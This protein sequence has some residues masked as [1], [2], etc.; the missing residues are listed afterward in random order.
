MELS[1]GTSGFELRGADGRVALG[2]ALPAVVATVD[3][4]RREWAPSV[5]EERD[6]T[7]VARGGPGGLGIELR[8]RA[9]GEAPAVEA[10]VVHPG[11]RPLHVD[12]LDLFAADGLVVGEDP[13]RWR[14]Y[15]NGYQSWAGTRTIGTEESDRDVP[16]QLVRLSTTD[17]RHRSPS[18]R[19][20]VR[21]DAVGA[22]CEPVT[23]DALAV[24]LT[25]ESDAFGFV[26]LGSA[27]ANHLSVWVDLDGVPLEPGAATPWFGA[28]LAAATGRDAG[29]TALRSVLAAVG[30]DHGALGRDRPH[31]AG[32]CSWYYY[33][34][35]V[36]EADVVE[37]LEVLAAD[38]R[39]GPVFGCE[40]VMV[41]DG[42]QRAIGDWL[43]TD[44]TK[45]PS[46]MAAVAQRITG[47]GFDAGLWW[48]PFLVDPD[49]EVAR[50]HPDWLVRNA[51]GRPIVGILNPV[52]SA[53]RPMQVLDT[54]H[55]EVL[56]HLE[57]VARVVGADWGYRI[58][59]LD[60]LYAAALP[61]RRHDPA[62]TRAASLRRG[63]EAV[64]RGA[65]GDGFL[66]GCGC[67]LGPAVG[68]VDA[69]RI[70]ADVTPYWSNAID[71]VGGGGWHALATRNAVQDTCARSPFDG[72]WWL[73]DPDCL[74]V[75]D[76]DTRLTEEEVRTLATVIGMTDG[77]V[78]LSDR[79]ARLPES[80]RRMI[81]TVRDLAGGR[82]EVADL[83]ERPRPEVLVSRRAGRTDV[84][85]VN[86]SDRPRRMA[87]DLPRRGVPVVDADLPE[88]WTGATVAVRGGLADLGEVP[89]HG[90]RVLRVVG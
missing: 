13:R 5:L 60:F 53:L 80:R 31:P 81:A 57:H 58:Q 59:K 10:R 30:D 25:A 29:W 39:D 63:L 72:T 3:G 82:V 45:F 46:G 50:S 78:V 86:T 87:V 40:Y 90:T 4:R 52:W 66:L 21:S 23:G 74:M 34:A 55:P 8:V 69:M 79:L 62:A 33:F 9:S 38:G 35:K 43:S 22:V 77:M 88:V 67:P 44:R 64:R 2:P 12:R 61:G 17:A 15:R 48:A 51:R 24:A 68:L 49:S 56:A 27:G 42:H 36:T 16:V 76:T 11:G 28:R 41:D 37:N 18:Q 20:R 54:T 32:W 19:G 84:A 73:N 83:F 70:G 26:E 71:R 65:G 1:C 85:V 7:W 14:A 89:A 6:G 75:R 47:A